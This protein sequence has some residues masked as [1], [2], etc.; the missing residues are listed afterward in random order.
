MMGS[1]SK[2]STL[3]R[4]PFW[5]Y[6]ELLTIFIA[7]P[8]VFFLYPSRWLIHLTLLILAGYAFSLLRLLTGTTWLSI[9]HGQEWSSRDRR[10]AF[11]RFLVSTFFLIVVT[12]LKLPERFFF[13]PQHYPLL[14]VVIMFLY[15][16]LSVF[17]QEIL[18]RTYL[19]AR[20]Q[21]ILPSLIARY[22]L[23]ALSFGYV[24]IVFH[25]W[26]APLLSLIGGAF[27]SF[28]YYQHQSLKWAA[29][30]HAAYGCMVF[31]VGIGA[32]F[33][34]NSPLFSP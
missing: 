16:L 10:F 13:L 22:T 31:T 1:Y 18:F 19:I 30:E 25:N 21:R 17:P 34:V 2:I 6:A 15:P 3:L 27:F 24:H 9:W 32:Y 11:Y 29:L 26:V 8:F 28:S 5:Q 20:Y 7:I 4:S 23:S 33:V 14:W 12:F